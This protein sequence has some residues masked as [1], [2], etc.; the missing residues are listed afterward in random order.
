MNKFNN[1]YFL[2]VIRFIIGSFF[3]YFATDKISDPE[4]F[5]LSIENYRFFPV[6]VINIIALTLPWIEVITGILLL[7]GVKVRENSFIINTLLVCFNLIIIIALLRGLDI[8]CGCFGSAHTQKIGLMKLTENFLLL[9][10]GILLQIHN[11][12]FMSITGKDADR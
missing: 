1:K 8:D 3:I 2:L 11:S 5:A 10:S 6:F 7:L 12:D 9:F 4:S